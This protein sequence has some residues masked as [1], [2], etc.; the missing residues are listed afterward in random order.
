M[1]IVSMI[2]PMMVVTMVMAVI[3]GMIVTVIV[4]VRVLR[5]I[6]MV[7]V[8][9]MIVM[10]VIGGGRGL[11]RTRVKRA[12]RGAVHVAERHTTFYGNACTVVELGCEHRLLIA[13]PTEF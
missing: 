6:V 4:R 2:M 9:M 10:V 7:V 8:V 13:A 3:V 11:D 5:V 12:L 1:V